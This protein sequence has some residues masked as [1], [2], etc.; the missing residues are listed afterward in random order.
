MKL[1]KIAIYTLAGALLMG[2]PACDDFLELEPISEATTENAYKTASDAEAAL[3]GVYE[4]FQAEYYIWDNLVFSEI[5]SDNYYAGGDNAEIFAVDNVAITPTNS[6]LWNNWSQIYNAIAKANVVLQKVPQITDPQLS[7]TRKAQILGEAAFLRAY[8]YFQLVKM[9]GGVPLVLE[10][11]TSLD[12]SV[13]QK[14]RASEVEVYNQIVT[15]LAFALENRLPDSYGDNASVNKARATR[16]AANALLAKVWAQRP[17]RDYNRVLQYADAVI[18]SPAGYELLANFN[19]LF[20]GAHYNNAESIM[21]VQFIGGNEANWGPQMLLPPSLSGDT[22]RKF[23]TPSHNLV[24]AYDS[25]KDNIR[26]N[27]TILFENAPWSDEFW[28]V[29]TGGSIP[30]AYRWKS[31]SGWASTNRQYIFRL[32]DIM[33]LKAEA[34]NELG[35]LEDARTVLN[36]VRRRVSLGPNTSTNQ[37]EMRD[38]IL[39]ERRL[40]LAQEG[41]RWDDLRRLGKAIET[42]ENLEEIDLRTNT[43]KEYNVAPHELF[44]PIPQSEINRNPQ[45]VQ[46]PGYN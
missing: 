12:P 36:T 7:G 35:R 4:S 21:E 32:A 23:M 17:D 6:R 30:F 9:W 40:E 24:E 14:P 38:A 28:S 33:L 15:D 29:S 13:T 41:H 27:T 8:H 10:P 18:N 46:T 1:N 26:K 22:W 3:T 44:L 37:E 34:L 39:K 43:P 20:D 16:G 11:V 42:M 5:L 19:H 2:A 25:E 45:L 31:A